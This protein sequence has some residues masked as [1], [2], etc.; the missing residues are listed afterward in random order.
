M[1]SRSSRQL[2]FHNWPVVTETSENKGAEV[3]EF[4]LYFFKLKKYFQLIILS[5][6]TGVLIVY[7]NIL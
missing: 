3:G 4:F 7:E 1:K 2:V 6:W 5:F